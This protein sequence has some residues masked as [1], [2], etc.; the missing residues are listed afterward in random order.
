MSKRERITLRQKKKIARLIKK[1]KVPKDMSYC[2]ETGEVVLP[3]GQM[4]KIPQEY[5][6]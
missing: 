3:S 4:F 5:I 2:E 1:G 6:V